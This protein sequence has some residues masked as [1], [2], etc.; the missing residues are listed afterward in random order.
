[1][2]RFTVR[3]SEFFG[4]EQIF[5]AYD[6]IPRGPVDEADQELPGPEDLVPLLGK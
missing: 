5:N 6:R 4:Y 3:V 1:M 2:E